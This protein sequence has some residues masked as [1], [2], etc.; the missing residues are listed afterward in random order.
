MRLRSIGKG[1]LV[2]K[3]ARLT[4]LSPDLREKQTRLRVSVF[5]APPQAAACEQLPHNATGSGWPV[6]PF[7]VVGIG[8][9]YVKMAT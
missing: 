4:T 6:C 9:N 1:N 5:P 7:R 8:Y 3:S 2:E